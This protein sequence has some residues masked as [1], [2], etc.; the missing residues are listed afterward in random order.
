MYI[1]IQFWNW[2]TSQIIGGAL[3]VNSFLASVVFCRL[4]KIFQNFGQ[5]SQLTEHRSRTRCYKTFFMPNSTEHEN[6]TASQ[7]LKYWQIKKFPALSILIVVFIMLINVKMLT[8]VDIFT[9][10]SRIN[11]VLSWVNHE[12]AGPGH[13]VI[14]LFNAQLSWARNLS[15]S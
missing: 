9:F 15:C 14:K 6:S 5:K 3:R 2:T 4:L 10:M 11:F 12:T 13:E 7:K 1:G 8:I